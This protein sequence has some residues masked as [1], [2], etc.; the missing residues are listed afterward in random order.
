MQ[1]ASY[2][3]DLLFRYEC[4]IIPGFGAF[5]TQ[6]HSAKID[7][8]SNTFTP[9]GKLVSF[10]RQ[11]QTN[12][13]LLANY[14]A[15]IEKCSYETS[16]QR[17]RNYT[18]NLS[19]Q[20]SEGKTVTIKNIGDF[21][22]NTEQTIQFTPS[23]TKNFNTASFGLTSFVSTNISR[24]Q[25]QKTVAALEEKAPIYISPEKRYAH[26]YLKYAAIALIAV[27]AIGYGG[28]KVYEGSVQE[29]NFAE[30]QKANSLIDSQ[31][32]EATFFIENPLPSLNVTVTKQT[33]KYHI[34]AGAFRVKEN[35][36]KKITQLSEQGFAANMIGVNKYGLHQVAY[37]SYENRLEA[38]Q[39]LRSI[40]KVNDKDAWLL[41]LDLNK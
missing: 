3:N 2:I 7:E 23:E 12:D 14:I 10:N 38:L 25:Y 27:S 40:K 8:S 36:E 5:L 39:T 20:L 17:I 35:A 30:K 41:V 6:Y 26:P 15:T 33:G 18:G 24:E 9:P 13:G 32:Q 22:L 4:V 11:L 34:I 28:I 19:L 21:V 1:L 31:I 16:L 29:H 37:S